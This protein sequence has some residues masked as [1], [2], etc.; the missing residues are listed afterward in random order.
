[1][2]LV[3]IL[4]IIIIILSFYIY[5]LATR[6]IC[7]NSTHLVGKV[8]IVTG[9]NSGIG[10]EIAK[11]AA[12][13][14]ARV[15]LACRNEQKSI[16]AVDNI[17]KSTKNQD[18][19]YYHLDLASFASIR[20]FAGI[21][22][23]TE[24]RLD[25]L[26]NNAGTLTGANDA[27]EDGYSLIMQT[28]HLGPFILTKL[29][30]PLLKTSAPSRVI[31]TASAMHRMVSVNAEDMSRKPNSRTLINAIV[32]FK[33]KLCN[34]LMT[35]ELDR[36]LKGT[37]VTVNCFDPGVVYTP[38]IHYID[39]KLI[40]YVLILFRSFYKKPWEGAQTCIYLAVS[41]D[42]ENVSGCYFKDCKISKASKTAHDLEL[43]QT[44]WNESEKCVNL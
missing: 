5:N 36:R 17:K 18:V 23:E 20:K 27:T 31:I 32:Y 41:P 14:G 38:M 22:I 37:G 15:I 6:G 44:I 24:K 9:A 39:Y 34:I 10:F 12:E 26:I 35:F 1:M 4:I 33:S 2:W 29:L 11:D 8:V 16:E 25:I 30:I 43:A 28:N 40:R 13:R 7:T 3:S 42:V 19:F 21:V